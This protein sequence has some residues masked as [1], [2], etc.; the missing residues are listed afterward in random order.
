VNATTHFRFLPPVGLV[1]IAT[2]SSGGFS[3]L[4]FFKT[5]KVRG[6]AYVEGSRLHSV[7]DEAVP[8]FRIDTTEKEL[9][10][11]YLV[12]ENRQL[13]DSGA[14]GPALSLLFVSGH[15]P[16]RGDAHYDVAKWNYSNYL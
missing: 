15:V 7:V 1:P 9:I 14:T 10:W 5:L 13:I 12:R 4:E 3:Q 16:Y 8:Y 2:S 11:L 6:P